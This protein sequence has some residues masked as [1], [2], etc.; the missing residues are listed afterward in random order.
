M[1]NKS[2]RIFENGHCSQS[3]VESSILTPGIYYPRNNNSRFFSTRQNRRKSDRRRVTQK[4]GEINVEKFINP[5]FRIFSHWFITLVEARW[6]WTLLNFFVTYIVDWLFFGLVYWLILFRHGDLSEDHLPQNQNVSNWTPC[7]KNIY[8]FT[9]TFLFSIEV[10]TTVA[11]GKRAITLECPDAIFA[12]C[13]QCIFSSIFQ[14][15]M[16]GILFAK[17]TRPKARTQT[18]LFSKNAIIALRDEKLCMIFRVGDIRK[19]RILNIKVSMFIVKLEI[20]SEFLDDAEQIEMKVELDGCES[21]FF[22]WP[23]AVVHIIDEMSP[24]YKISAADLFCGRLEI[25]AVFE[26]IIESTGQPVQAR[27]SYTENDIIWGH[28]FVPLMNYRSSNEMFDVDFSKLNITEQIDTP[29]CS[30]Q[31]YDF[32]VTSVRHSVCT[33]DNSN[34]P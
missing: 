31:E 6:R 28:R 23:V 21:S 20:G 8:G 9:S 27:S 24:L 5:K 2:R 14:S 15:F 25:L 7:I 4:N 30:S 26:G 13:I 16:I 12:M 22:L 19:S 34:I 1:T 11:Y 18:I 3:S 10:H 33:S 32:L 17:L 29:L